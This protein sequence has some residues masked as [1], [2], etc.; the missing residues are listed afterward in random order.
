[1]RGTTEDVNHV[2]M[3]LFFTLPVCSQGEFNVKLTK[4]QNQKISFPTI[5]DKEMQNIFTT[6]MLYLTNFWFFRFNE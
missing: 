2:L 4:R 3:S 5:Y 6:E 1:M